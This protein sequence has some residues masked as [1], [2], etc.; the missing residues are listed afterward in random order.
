MVVG[1]WSIQVQGHYLQEL[2][3]DIIPLTSLYQIS[4]WDDV[5]FFVYITSIQNIHA[6]SEI[7]LL[8]CPQT[9]NRMI[10]MD[11]FPVQVVSF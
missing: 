5:Y 10:L 2:Q 7:W 1:P 3:V 9:P 11:C 8:F 6:H 4:D